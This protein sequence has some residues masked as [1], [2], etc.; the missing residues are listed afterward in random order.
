MWAAGYFSPHSAIWRKIGIKSW[1]FC[2]S[3]YSV[4]GGTSANVLRVTIPYCSRSSSRWLSVRGLMPSSERSSVQ[5]RWQPVERSRIMSAVHLLPSICR[6][7]ATQP[8]VASIGFSAVVMFIL[9][10]LICSNV[11]NTLLCIVMGLY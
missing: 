7:A 3:V 5:K 8:V 2:V 9:V 10:Y 6:A 1:P 4:R 11:F